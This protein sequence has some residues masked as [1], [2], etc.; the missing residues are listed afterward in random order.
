MVLALPESDWTEK[1]IETAIK[2]KNEG[3]SMTTIGNAVGKSR[4]SVAG[5]IHRLRMK[6]NSGIDAAQRKYQ[7][8]KS[9]PKTKPSPVRTP[10]YSIDELVKRITPENVHPEIPISPPVEQRRIR[11][12]IV[13]SE[14]AVTITELQPRHCR[15]PLG[16]P[17]QSD[18]RYCGCDR[19][20]D[21]KP[22]CAEHT[23]LTTQGVVSRV[24][25]NNSV[26]G[27]RPLVQTG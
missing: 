23:K 21:Q 5:K 2:M 6:P 13:T 17:K 7:T 8:H 1:E 26:P 3:A 4:N 22:Y 12:R 16:D 27:N 11:L 10:I 20:S 14:T 15:Y 9:I 19:V 18:F 25:V 24:R